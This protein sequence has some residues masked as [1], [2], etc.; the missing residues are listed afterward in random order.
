MSLLDVRGINVFYGAVQ[1]IY[2][3]SFTVSEGEIV[4]IVGANGAGKT[5]TL[6][7]IA[8]LLKVKQ[9]EIYFNNCRIDGMSPQ[10]IVKLGIS[11]VPEGR[12]LFPEMTV[13][14]NLELGAL[15]IPHAKAKMK[16]TLEWIWDLFP[17][18]AER[19]RQL[20]GTL[21]GGEQQMLA[22]ARG[23]M[24]MPKLLMLDEPSLGLAPKIVQ[25]I[26]KAISDINKKG[27]A[28]L[29]VEQ[30]VR[31]SLLISDRAYVLETGRV[32]LEGTSQEV[33][34][35]EHVKRAYLGL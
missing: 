12:E 21:S 15:F 27:I 1:V 5:T 17:I 20:A 14:E 23:M 8:G 28:V 19:K 4:A 6:N 7:T 9:G 25:N 18:L 29:L 33:L 2:D 26:F 31:H 10:D 3:V 11:L 35:N 16:K 24:S 34:D 13:L 22:I 30:N 32:V